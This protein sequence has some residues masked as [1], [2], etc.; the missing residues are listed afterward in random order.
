M[1]LFET[2]FISWLMRCPL[3]WEMQS[4]QR[5]HH[6]PVLSSTLEYVSIG[7]GEGRVLV[8]VIERGCCPNMARPFI[9]FRGE[10]VLR[11]LWAY[12]G[13]SIGSKPR[14]RISWTLSELNG[15]GLHIKPGVD[16]AL[17]YARV[18]DR[19]ECIPRLEQQS[20]FKC[21]IRTEF[22]IQD[23]DVRNQGF[24]VALGTDLARVEL[25]RRV[26]VVMTYQ[27]V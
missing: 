21:T 23:L 7:Q 8:R 3:C 19:D 4:L 15:T 22:L 13:I 24:W 20:P 11:E 27:V 2:T 5:L 17:G 16:Q 18:T 26:S 1:C 25:S 9:S 12:S 10:T 6:L 14:K